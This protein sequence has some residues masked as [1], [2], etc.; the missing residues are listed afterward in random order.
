MHTSYLITALSLT[1]AVLAVPQASSQIPPLV[2]GVSLVR[3]MLTV[4]S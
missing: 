1:S 3:I 4:A 2:A